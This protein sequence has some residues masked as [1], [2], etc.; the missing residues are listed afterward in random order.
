MLND[1]A[2]GGINSHLY[3]SYNVMCG[4]IIRHNLHVKSK[5]LRIREQ[6]TAAHNLH[7][8]CILIVI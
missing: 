5:F 8:K 4:S 1:S 6:K 2:Y 3:T 7:H